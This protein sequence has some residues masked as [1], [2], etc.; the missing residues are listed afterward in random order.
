VAF[1]NFVCDNIAVTINTT[2][3]Q[4]LDIE[5]ALVSEEN[6]ARDDSTFDY[7]RCAR[8]HNYLVAYG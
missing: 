7:E 1:P 2:V 3:E 6:P 5:D 4:L 8:L